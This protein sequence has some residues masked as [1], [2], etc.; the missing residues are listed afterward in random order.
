MEN[1]ALLGATLVASDNDDDPETSPDKRHDGRRVCWPHRNESPFA[2]RLPR[3]ARREP[4][5]CRVRLFKLPE[6]NLSGVVLGRRGKVPWSWDTSVEKGA[7]NGG[8]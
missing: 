1:A 6:A 4:G 7:I 3:L 2:V 8:G 5:R